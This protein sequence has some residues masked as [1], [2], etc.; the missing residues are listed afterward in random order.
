MPTTTPATRWQEWLS[1][2]RLASLV[3]GVFFV[4]WLAAQL[5]WPDDQ[6]FPPEFTIL[7]MGMVGSAFTNVM[8]QAQKKT[9][10]TEAKVAVL[11]EQMT[12]EQGR[13]ADLEKRADVSH[14]R[15]DAAERRESGWSRHRNH[16]DETHDESGP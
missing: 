6:P 11:E 9:A 10:E 5:L 12:H 3:A 14:D 2:G 16:S 13:N 1:N 15:A 8:L 4:G 7:V